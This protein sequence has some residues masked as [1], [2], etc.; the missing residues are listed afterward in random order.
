MN[1]LPTRPPTD[2]ERLVAQGLAAR[3]L[4]IP[5]RHPTPLCSCGVPLSWTDKLGRPVVHSCDPKE[6]C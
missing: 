6:T 3:V 2:E 1:D 4:A 5:R